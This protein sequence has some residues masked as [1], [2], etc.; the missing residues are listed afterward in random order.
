MAAPSSQSQSTITFATRPPAT[1]PTCLDSRIPRVC[2]RHPEY[3]SN[4]NNILLNLPA[5]DEA[6]ITSD[7][8]QAASAEIRRGLH[9]RTAWTAGA[10][11]ANN[12]FDRAYL[13]YDQAGRNR[14][15]AVVPLDGV[16]PPGDYWLHLQREEMVPSQSES[17]SISSPHMQTSPAKL[18]L[19]PYPIVPSFGDWRFPHGR[20]PSEW[21]SVYEAPSREASGANSPSTLSA[22]VAPSPRPTSAEPSCCVSGSH[23]AV[24]YCRLIPRPDPWKE[25]FNSNAMSQYALDPWC[26]IQDIANLVPMRSDIH[27]L[28]DSNRFT[29]A[30]KPSTPGCYAL[31][32][33]VL[34][35]GIDELVPLYHNVAIQPSSAP[36]FGREFL[37]ARFAL[38]IFPLVM[39]FV[40]SPAP[41]YLAISNLED[42][43]EPSKFAW[44]NGP[45][46]ALH[47]D[48]RGESRTGSKR[49][50]SQMS[51]DQQVEAEYDDCYSR[52]KR[53]SHVSEEL[54]RCTQW[55]LEHGQS[56]NAT[57]CVEMDRLE[58]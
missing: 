35:D 21:K 19:E 41:R 32:I 33:H 58:A 12:A 49:T 8:G 1:P 38:S 56:T 55:C 16:L 6:T 24:E 25:W 48:R 34:N 4:P 53:C 39:S 23:S 26:G 43:S 29:V 11:I 20:L 15:D 47:L 18:T 30:P 10:I 50:F 36:L 51:P 42:H 27:F 31:A 14:V 17:S 22:T 46:F 52:R 57:G 9:H 37:F 2:I 7:G 13:T 5:V 44:M 45:Q 40:D 54:W 28:F 3:G